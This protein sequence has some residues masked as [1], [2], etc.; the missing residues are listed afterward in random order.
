MEEAKQLRKSS[1]RT[2]LLKTDLHV[3]VGGK[4]EVAEINK[5]FEGRRKPTIQ[6]ITS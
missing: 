1:A 3:R 5:G 4:E 2:F 6:D